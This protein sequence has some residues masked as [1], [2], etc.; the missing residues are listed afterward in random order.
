MTENNAYANGVVEMLACIAYNIELVV[1]P[2]SDEAYSCAQL[3]R[4]VQ[5]QISFDVLNYC[6]EQF[7]WWYA[8]SSRIVFIHKNK[9]KSPLVESPMNLQ[10]SEQLYYMFLKY[11]RES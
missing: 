11:A 2:H 7:S 1:F 5:P 3:I 9:F 4:N 10:Q 6:A 8:S